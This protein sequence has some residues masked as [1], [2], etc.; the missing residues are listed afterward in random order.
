[1]DVPDF[2]NY[3]NTLPDKFSKEYKQGFLLGDFNILT[4]LQ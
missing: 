3:L 2:K 1:M 4:T